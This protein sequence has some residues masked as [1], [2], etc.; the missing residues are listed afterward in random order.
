MMLD[1]LGNLGDFVGGLAVVVTLIYLALQIR[2]N[3][4]TTR[5]QT[6]QHLLTSDTASAD[7]MISGPLPEILAKQAAGERLTPSEVSA[8]TLYMRGRVTEAWQVFYQ[9]QNGM[10]EDKVAAA[11]LGRFEF[12]AGAPLFRAVWQHKLKVGFPPEFQ[13]YIESRILDNSRQAVA[14][15][16]TSTV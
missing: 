9:R 16:E 13:D 14:P 2:R 10:I 3:T 11:L 6:V 8:Y 7:L 4:S 12:F 5:V 15:P 1:E